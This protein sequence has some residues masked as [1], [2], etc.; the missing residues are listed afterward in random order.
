VMTDGEPGVSH[1]GIAVIPWRRDL[2]VVGLPRERGIAHV[3][4]WC[5]DGIDASAFVVLPFETKAV[6]HLNLV[7]ALEI[8]PAVATVLPAILR[9]IRKAKFDMPGGIAEVVLRDD[10]FR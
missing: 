6:E 9:L 7:A 3:E 2:D 4:L 1:L 5:G 10:T 8:R